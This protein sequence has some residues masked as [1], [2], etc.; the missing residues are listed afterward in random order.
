MVVIFGKPP[1]Y[2]RVEAQLGAGIASS[3]SV[4]R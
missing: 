4:R 1:I 2:E 3:S